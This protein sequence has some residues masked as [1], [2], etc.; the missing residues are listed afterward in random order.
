MFQY[1]NVTNK[2]IRSIQDV[3]MHARSTRPHKQKKLPSNIGLTWLVTVA[4]YKYV[5]PYNS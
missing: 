1:I 2:A 3:M 5:S 4:Q